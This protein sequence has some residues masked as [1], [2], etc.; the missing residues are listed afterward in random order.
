MKQCSR[1]QFSWGAYFR[2]AI[3]SGAFFREAFSRG[4][5]S[6]NPNK[7]CELLISDGFHTFKHSYMKVWKRRKFF[8]L[9]S[10]LIL[11]V[12]DLST[13]RQDLE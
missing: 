1:G 5:F 11:F 3:F 8:Y 7:Q 6:G 4:H 10:V 13:R 9:C 12:L 2:G